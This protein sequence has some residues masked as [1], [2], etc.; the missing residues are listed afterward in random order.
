MKKEVVSMLDL[1]LTFIWTL[2]QE[3]L[4][5]VFIYLLIIKDCYRWKLW[6]EIC[7]AYAFKMLLAFSSYV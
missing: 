4:I 6:K 2:M 1:F 5:G 7:L 3:P